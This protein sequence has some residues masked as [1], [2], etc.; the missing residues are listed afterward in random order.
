VIA[1]LAYYDTLTGLPNRTRLRDLMSKAITD[2]PAG[3]HVALAFLDVDNFAHSA[4]RAREMLRHIGRS[5]SDAPASA[6]V[7]AV[8]T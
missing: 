1:R 7:A 5:L 8:Q 3:Q 4:E 2:C 6:R